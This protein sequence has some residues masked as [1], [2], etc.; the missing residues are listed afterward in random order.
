MWYRGRPSVQEYQTIEGKQRRK[1][2]KPDIVEVNNCTD[3]FPSSIFLDWRQ[4][5][6]QFRTPQ[7]V[8][9]NQY[10]L[11]VK[12]SIIHI[13]EVSP[14]WPKKCAIFQRPH[15]GVKLHPS[16]AVVQP[17]KSTTEKRHFEDKNTPAVSCCW[18]FERH[19][20]CWRT[21]SRQGWASQCCARQPSWSDFP[22]QSD[23]RARQTSP[24]ARGRIS[25]P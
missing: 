5:V 10:N 17:Q 20:C 23:D 7:L 16:I 24:E 18:H 2:L 8:P 3:V 6:P 15:R 21:S 13:C 11:S 9:D 25:I 19:S 14:Y 22:P 4:P 12:R 1:Y